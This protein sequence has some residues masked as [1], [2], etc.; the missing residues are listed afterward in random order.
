M[1][2]LIKHMLVN[3]EEAQAVKIIFDMY[4]NGYS[5]SNIIDKLNDLGYKTK[6][7]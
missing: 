3:E 4:V 2:R 5:Y 6:E 1:L 7:R